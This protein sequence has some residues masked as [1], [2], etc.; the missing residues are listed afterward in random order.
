[1]EFK[2]KL[3]RVTFLGLHSSGWKGN[4]EKKSELVNF[5][6]AIKLIFALLRYVQSGTVD[7][8]KKSLFAAS[9]RG[10]CA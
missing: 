2:G 1:M 6:I 9:G 5:P 10:D 8:Q 7:T 3:T 4:A